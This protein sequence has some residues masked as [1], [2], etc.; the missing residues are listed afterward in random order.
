[1]K[2]ELQ[3]AGRKGALAQEHKN[4]KQIWDYYLYSVFPHPPWND[5]GSE[6]RVCI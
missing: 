4:A 2:S 5:H 3:M 1:V 6:N